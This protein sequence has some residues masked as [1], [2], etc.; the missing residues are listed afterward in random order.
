MKRPST[1]NPSSGN[2][3]QSSS[4]YPS[5][6]HQG[7]GGYQPPVFYAEDQTKTLQDT[8]KTFY[9]ADETAGHVLDQMQAQRQ[10]IAGASD[11]VWQ[12]RAATEQARR[13]MEELRQKYRRKK[14]RLYLWIGALAITDF[15][16]FLRILQCHGNFYCIY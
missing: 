2:K 12:M 15:L 5:Y 14:Q 6:Q 13:E 16:L 10:Q 7:S 1:S 4:S 9:Q 3:G 11:N 8:T